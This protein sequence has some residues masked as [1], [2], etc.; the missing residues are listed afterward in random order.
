M[1]KTLSFAAAMLL[2]A[3]VVACG[4]GAS[5]PTATPAP[6]PAATPTLAAP[7]PTV[8]PAAAASPTA[9]PPTPTIAASPTG[10]APAAT[11]PV[12]PVATQPPP[13][14]AATATPAADEPLDEQALLELAYLRPEELPGS[15]TLDDA[16]VP[17]ALQEGDGSI[18]NVAPFEQRDTRLARLRAELSEGSIPAFVIH[19]LAVFP[20]DVAPEAMAYARQS[21][22]ACTEWTNAAGQ[23]F[24]VAPL[25]DPLLGDESFAVRIAFTT[26]GMDFES[27]W[28]FARV[29]GFVMSVT[30]LTSAVGQLERGE[31]IAQ[32]ATAKL[33]AAA[34]SAYFPEFE[35]A[36]LVDAASL[37]LTR[38]E[39]GQEWTNSRVEIPVAEDRYGVCAAAPFP[40]LYG[41]LAEIAVDF[42]ADPAT[43]PF[44]WHSI[45]V[46]EEGGGDAVMQ[47]LREEM[48]C[49]VWEDNGEQVPVQQIETSLLGDDSFAVLATLDV[50]DVAT[51]NV[52][53]LFIQAGDVINV[54]GYAVLGDL[55]PLVVE[56]YARMALVKL[57]L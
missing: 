45:V 25:D 57:G 33:A 20:P 6:A 56:Q 29:E 51:V 43:G 5:D 10:T 16:F 8:P 46:L 39:L 14:Q 41:A 4:G 19:D 42:E 55:D 18:C 34:Q 31:L 12:R 9:S 47:Y 1:R 38:A 24:S 23:L 40:D 36:L 3:L 17:D 35:P 48:S 54:I 53:Y 30:F 37:L 13:A 2:S 50:P 49:S 44:L 52:E 22:A 21:S 11:A 7:T 28:Y 15:W 32:L 26:S 27:D